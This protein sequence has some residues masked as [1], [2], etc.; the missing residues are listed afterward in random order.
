MSTMIKI[1][2]GPPDKLSKISFAIVGVSLLATIAVG[3][4]VYPELT[5][6]LELTKVSVIVWPGPAA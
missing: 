4:A 5:A 1:V 3:Y 6:S 2:N